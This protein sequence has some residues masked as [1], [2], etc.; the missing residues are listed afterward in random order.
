M[1]SLFTIALMFKAIDQA[2]APIRK[3]D[4][5]VGGVGKT[6]DGAAGKSAGLRSGLDRAGTAAGGL[7]AAAA[8]AAQ[9]FNQAFDGMIAK[10]KA[11]SEKMKEA[12]ERAQIGAAASGAGVVKALD[13]FKTLEASQ[14]NLQVAMMGK[15]GVVNQA[16][17][18]E[19]SRL[20]RQF[21]KDYMGSTEDFYKMFR[22]LQEQG[23]KTKD[24]LSGT[25]KAVSDFAAVTGEGYNEAA[26]KIA[27]FQDSFG[28]AARDMP[29]F[30][31]QLSKAKFAFGLDTT[32]VYY[33]MPYLSG[34]LKQVGMQGLAASNSVLRMAGIMSQAGIPASQIGESLNQVFNRMAD[35]DTRLNKKSKQM[36][37]IRGILAG[38]G[39]E[40]NFWDQNE[41]FA[42]VENMI[43]QFEK[44]KGLTDKQKIE[45]GQKLFGDVG[46]KAV[47]I[48][49]EKGVKGWKESEKAMKRQAALSERVAAIQKT[50]AFLW[51]SFTGTVKTFVAAIGEAI[52]NSTG[53]K[54]ILGKLND[55]FDFA[56]RWIEN[57]KKIAAAIGIAMAATAALTAGVVALGGAVM[58]GGSILSAYGTGL[59]AIKF[60]AGPAVREV[61]LLIL[62]MRG[63]NAAQVQRG[64]F[65]EIIGSAPVTRSRIF[66]AVV[67]MKAWSVAQ[68]SAF[69]ANFLT[70]AGLKGMASAFGSHL[71]SGIRLV[72]TAMRA[73][74][75][76]MLLNPVGLAIA[77]IA[78]AALVII[79]YW[80]PIKAFFSGLWQGFKEGLSPLKEL[81]KSARAAAKPLKEMFA[82]VIGLI[83]Q[84]L[85]PLGFTNK[86]LSTTALIGKGIGY[87]LAM[88][89]TMPIYAITGILKAIRMLFTSTKQFF[90]AGANI[91][92][93]IA[94]GITSAISHPVEAIKGVVKRIRN[95]LPFSPAKEGPLRD[96]NRVRIVETIAESMRP[97]PLVKAMKAA[98]AAAMIAAAPATVL[99]RPATA[100][101]RPAVQSLARPSASAPAGGAMQISF[102]PQITIQGGGNTDQVRHQVNEAMTISFAE[103]ERLMKRYEEQRTR[104]SF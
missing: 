49:S 96:I 63:L 53:L 65:G 1:N 3:M 70:V 95:F 29:K 15:G 36:Q 66:E 55:A 38:T 54:I 59:S 12:G 72:T 14:V 32:E 42:G 43:A 80:K 62:A 11:L 71:L 104:R 47:A 28:I 90:S 89:F 67:A 69:R 75:L 50:L 34:A 79:A 60:A 31:D 74:S 61:K 2:T 46:G 97:A 45:I 30:T 37:E 40:L 76:S 7:G 13:A 88:A 58:V 21:G 26:L 64:M 103:F 92:K 100:P 98:T 101:G 8:R 20:A 93:S 6:L 73:F 16:D 25:G 57:H 81:F 78:A 102:S 85:T 33:A 5:A 18:A 19:L 35:F 24:I 9:R 91:V 68:L 83:K 39:I 44:L 87:I 22:V 52:T 86:T 4:E 23:I 56:S 77:G 51:D 27:K 10:T 94:Q 17:Y 84:F 48:F 82:P 41:K 99:A